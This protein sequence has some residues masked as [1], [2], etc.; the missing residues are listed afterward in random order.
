MAGPAADVAPRNGAKIGG[1]AVKRHT[2]SSKVLKSVLLSG[3]VFSGASLA[4]ASVAVAQ[5][6]GAAGPDVEKVVVTG[7]R[8]AKKN[9]SSSSPITTSTHDDLVN[10][11]DIT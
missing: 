7:S 10:N 11:G 8:I 1:S 5:D 2:I 6:T 3:A 9:L 4:G